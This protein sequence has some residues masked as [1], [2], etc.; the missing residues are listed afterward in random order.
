MT[1]VPQEL[2][3]QV[4]DRAQGR[5]EYCLLGEGDAF[6][7]HQVDHI[8]AEKHGGETTEANLCLSCADC[9]RYKG[10]DL[11]SIGP[12]TG[13]IV[14]LFHPRR[15][16]WTEHFRVDAGV[17]RPLTPQARIAVRL[18]RLND[19]QRVEERRRLAR[20]GRFPG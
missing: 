18:L 10:S 16:L 2:R 7:S 14:A 9:N 15:D 20:L 4:R 3:R 12:V 11:C 13:E 8:Y 19:E 17:I 6:W 1:H 5:C